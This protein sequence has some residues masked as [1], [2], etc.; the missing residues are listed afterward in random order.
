M[1]K[2][3][4]KTQWL[5]SV[6]AVRRLSNLQRSSAYGP[7][8]GKIVLPPDELAAGGI[9][10]RHHA[11]HSQR[12]DLSVGHDG[13][14]SRAGVLGGGTATAAA[15]LFRQ[16]SLPSAALRQRSTSSSPCRLKTYSLSPTKA[17]VESPRPTVVFH[18]WVRAFGQV[19]G[20]VNPVALPSRLGPRH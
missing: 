2:P 20:A 7:L 3:E 17:G 15:Y 8:A 18:F 5:I 10:A 16:S 19:A 14:A 4:R 11:R 6:T 12:D 1:Q 9:D 13:R